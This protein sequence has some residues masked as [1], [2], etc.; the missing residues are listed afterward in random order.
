MARVR[1]TMWSTD[2]RIPASFEATD[3]YGGFTKGRLDLP[4]KAATTSEIRVR[5]TGMNPKTV[6]YQSI[7]ALLAGVGGTKTYDGPLGITI[8]FDT[9]KGTIKGGIFRVIGVFPKRINPYAVV[10]QEDAMTKMKG[11]GVDTYKWT[12]SKTISATAGSNS[13]NVLELPLTTGLNG[14]DTV[15]EKND[16]VMLIDPPSNLV[17]GVMVTG[18]LTGTFP[19]A[20]IPHEVCIQVKNHDGTKVYQGSP[21]SVTSN[22]MTAVNASAM[23]YTNGDGHEFSTKGFQVHLINLSGEV[24]TLTALDLR[25]HTFSNPDFT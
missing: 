17:R 18:L 19:T 21:I 14:G 2:S 25:V 9:S 11:Y 3:G 6:T 13:M 20:N 22:T 23:L 12:G 15:I 1:E 8:E 10:T 4:Q 16:K 7:S 24:L 5:T